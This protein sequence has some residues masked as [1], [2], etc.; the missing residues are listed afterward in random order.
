MPWF[1]KPFQYQ[2]DL[3]RNRGGPYKTKPATDLTRWRLTNVD[4][5]QTWS[6]IPD[7]D[8]ADRPQSMLERYSLGLDTV[9]TNLKML[10]MVPYSFYLVPCFRK[11]FWGGR[12]LNLHQQNLG[13][14]SWWPPLSIGKISVPPHIFFKT[15]PC[16]MY[17][18]TLFAFF[19]FCFDN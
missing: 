12:V 11:H 7:E 15:P 10:L 1:S 14:P 17:C 2:N 5:R 6:Y 3:P 9:S 4:G 19:L 13:T 18:M 16:Y 8:T